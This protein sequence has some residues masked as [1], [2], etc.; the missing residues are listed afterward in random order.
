MIGK[1]HNNQTRF[2][3]D[4]DPDDSI[5]HSLDGFSWYGLYRNTRDDHGRFLAGS[6]VIE[7]TYG[8]VSRIDYSIGSELET[9]WQEIDLDLEREGFYWETESDLAAELIGSVA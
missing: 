3:Y 1:F 6:I 4:S 2:L 5:G 8:F 7:D 9:A